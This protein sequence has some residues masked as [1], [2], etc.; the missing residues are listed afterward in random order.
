MRK[1]HA[2][3]YTVLLDRYNLVASEILFIDDN[4]RNAKAAEEIGMTVIHFQSPQGLA[5]TLKEM[6]LL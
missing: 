4:F 6:D 2:E 3:F 5:S 1:P